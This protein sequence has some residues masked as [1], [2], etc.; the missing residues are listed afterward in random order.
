M[1]KRSITCLCLTLFAAVPVSAQSEISVPEDTKFVVKLDLVAFGKTDFG[2]KVLEMTEQLA[3][4]ELGDDEDVMQK[5]VETVGFNPLEEVK[6][7]TVMGQDYDNPEQGVR[8]MLQLGKTAGNLEGLALTLPNYASEEIGG[9]T[10]H[11]AHEDDMQG[12]ATIHTGK[13]GSK[14]VLA[15]TSREDLME[16]LHSVESSVAS[17]LQAAKAA[18]TP[19]QIS[20][21]VPSG[22]FAQVHVLEMPGELVENGPQ[23]NIAKLITDL[24]LTVGEADN[25]IAVSLSLTA[26]NEKKAEQLRQLAQG[27]KAMI[28]LFQDEVKGDKEAEIAMGILKE[29]TIEQ[30]GATLMLHADVP[31]ELI[32]V[33][34][35]EDGAL[36]IEADL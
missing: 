5:I 2:A 28:G 31:Q 11:S 32:M 10:I 21:A 24:S 13:S 9:H 8:M 16:M 34:I 19:R 4:S 25:K 29:V 30:D 20:W 18:A 23:A 14:T 33:Q 17:S 35:S 1:L 6:T 12:F 15:A 3:Q 7:L 36:E 22:T 26:A 27:A